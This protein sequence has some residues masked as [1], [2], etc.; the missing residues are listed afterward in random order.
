MFAADLLAGKRILVTGGGSGLGKAMARR[1]LELGAGVAICGRRPS[2]LEETARELAEATGG[3]I[4]CHPVDIRDAAAVDAMIEGLWRDGP[5]DA[6]VNNA[7]GNFISP[8][9]ELSPRGFDA[10]AGIVFHGTFYVTH[11]CGRRWLAG[12]HKGNIL[13]ILTTWIETGSPYV[14]PSAMSKAGVAAMTRSLAVEW[15]RRG[16]RANAIAPG[17]FPTEG[18]SARLAPREELRRDISETVPLGRP[19]EH[20][21]LANL[22]V[23]LLADQSAYVNGEI[24]F[25]DGGQWLTGRGTFDHLRKLTPEDWQAIRDEIKAA[26]AKDKAQRVS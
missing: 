12:G 17:P 10:V 22:A 21:E 5:L 4:T 26:N 14:V 3:T 18:A 7:A 9:E 24:V 19:G 2:V 13:S 1:F 6:L 23:Y 11:A 16:V 15:G 8:T 20:I 25:I